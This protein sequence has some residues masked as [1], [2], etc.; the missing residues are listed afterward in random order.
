M[1]SNKKFTSYLL[2]CLSTDKPPHQKGN[3]K[4][5]KPSMRYMV[6]REFAACRYLT[7]L[8]FHALPPQESRSR[9]RA[10]YSTSLHP[11]HTHHGDDVGSHFSFPFPTFPI[12]N[13]SSSYPNQHILSALL[14]VD[15]I[16]I[17]K[18]TRSCSPVLTPSIIEAIVSDL[19]FFSF[20]QYLHDRIN[21]LSP[22]SLS[23]INTASDVWFIV[24]GR[25]SLAAQW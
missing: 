1:C 11:A 8:Y 4:S 24:S 20:Y 14:F 19:F 23:S 13:S 17:A 9:D 2:N 25:S 12:T 7:D 22:S 6:G 16:F 3:T 18:R 21:H 10:D 15:Q 5:E